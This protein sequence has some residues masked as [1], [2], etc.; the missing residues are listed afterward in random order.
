MQPKPDSHIPDE[1]SADVTP[2]SPSL[3]QEEL[4]ALSQLGVKLRSRIYKNLLKLLVWKVEMSHLVVIIVSLGLF[5][6]GLLFV[7]HVCSLK[8]FR[9][10]LISEASAEVE[11]PKEKSQIDTKAEAIKSV[12]NESSKEESGKEEIDPLLLDENQIKVLLA[13][14]KKGKNIKETEQEADVEKQKKIIELAQE[15]LNKRIEELEKVKKGIESKK[16][17]LTKDEKQ[18]VT[19]MAKIYETMKPTQAADILNKLELTSLIQIIK[20]MNQKKAAAIVSSMEATKARQLT[21]EILKSKDIEGKNASVVEV[22]PTAALTP[23]PTVSLPATAPVSDTKSPVLAPP[24]IAPISETKSP[25]DGA[26]KDVP[27]PV[28]KT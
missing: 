5:Y 11:A 8:D 1:S 23:S 13:L 6:R 12:V 19:N 28:S 22:A 18:N 24:T 27:A 2:P 10:S 17:E 3:I 15:N 9:F 7:D 14:A 25:T 4:L 26:S 20:H 16:E 21:L